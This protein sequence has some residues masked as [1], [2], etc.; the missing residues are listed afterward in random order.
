MQLEKKMREH[1]IA[2]IP[3][4]G[5]GPEVIR[6]GVKVLETVSKKL[7]DI[8]FEFRYFPWG[9]EYYLKNG[10]MMP[11]DGLEKLEKFEAVY[12]G[13]IGDPR[14]PDH[15]S[16]REL[17]LKIRFGFDQYIN[18]RPVKLLEGVPCPLKNKGP[19]DIDFVVVREN[20][21]GFYT[22]VGGRYKRGSS[23][24]NRLAKIKKTFADSEKIVTQVGVFSSEGVE[25]V[26]RYAFGLAKRR[27]G[28]LTCCTKSNA[29]NYSMVYWDEVFKKV[30]KE[31]PE[32]KT[33]FAFVDAICMW[34]VKNPEFFDV[35]VAD[36]LFGD[37]ITDLGAMI[38]GG[39]GLAPGGNINPDG[40]SMFEPIHGSAP[41][42]TGRNVADP[43]A[44][45]WAGQM[46]L[47]QLGEKKAASMIMKA[48]KKV[49][50]DSKVR[51]KD[52]GGTSATSEVG[53][54]IVES[55]LK[56]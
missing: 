20:T 8:T 45:I 54:A 40:L 13:A 7:G 49:L 21:E 10:Q 16:L 35:I 29:L 12:L 4:D 43:I 52:L 30:A 53:D 44:T 50:K 31:Y 27:G 55:I 9:C 6:E 32:V 28:H 3:G 42:Y 56:M 25:R 38:Q 5:I 14:V 18:L 22:G 23:E 41:K 36:N 37:I 2:V 39:M 48:I 26:I 19:K 51:T 15:V 34:F 1:R 46:M 47:E 17:L 11:E 24:Y 33:D